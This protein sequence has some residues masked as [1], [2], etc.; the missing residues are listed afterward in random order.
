MEVKS[1]PLVG[2]D[3]KSHFPDKTKIKKGE[4]VS[5]RALKH[6]IHLQEMVSKDMNSYLVYCI[7]RGDSKGFN[8]SPNDSIYRNAVLEAIKNG[9]IVILIYFDWILVDSFAHCYVRHMKLLEN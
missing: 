7:Q 2:D 5:P 1:V 4:V 6:I 8:L 9:V 3:G